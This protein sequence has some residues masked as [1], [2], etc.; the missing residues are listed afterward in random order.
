MFGG[1]NTQCLGTLA[2]VPPLHGPYNFSPTHTNGPHLE[3]A[4]GAL[5]KNLSLSLLSQDSDTMIE[6]PLD[7]GGELINLYSTPILHKDELND[8]T[9]KF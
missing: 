4:N 2:G 9:Y 6:I 8:G 7:K 1:V 5:G 3:A